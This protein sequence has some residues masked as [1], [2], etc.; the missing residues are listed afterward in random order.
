M[1]TAP[2]NRK[3]PMALRDSSP[4]RP[5]HPITNSR[6][7]QPGDDKELLATLVPDN[8]GPNRTNPISIL[9]VEDN[10]INQKVIVS[11]LSQWKCNVTTAL[12]GLSGF[13]EVV[14]HQGGK[15]FDLVLCDLH[16][17]AC[18]GFQCV[19]MI[20]DWEEKNGVPPMRIC[21]VT[22]DASP[23]T[24]ERCLEEAGFNEFMAKPLRKNELRDMIIKMCGENR[25]NVTSTQTMAHTTKALSGSS[26]EQEEKHADMTDG[27]GGTR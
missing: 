5:G 16:M 3:G 22:A 9:H 26:L 14:S 19:K 27:I 15:D 12:N 21:A 25:L 8:N 11:I 7:G 20:R 2:N 4:V 1:L 23:E 18:D 13:E 10:L 24:R 17:P 6:R